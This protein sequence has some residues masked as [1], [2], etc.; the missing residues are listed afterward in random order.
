MVKSNEFFSENYKQSEA[1]QEEITNL[2]TKEEF[3]V[4]PFDIQS[5]FEK[6]NDNCPIK[7]EHMGNKIP[8][9]RWILYNNISRPDLV[10]KYKKPLLIEIKHKNKKYLWINSRDYLDYIKWEDILLI[11]VYIIMFVKDENIFYIHRLE[12]DTT[13]LKSL[14]TQHDGNKVFD[15]QK[16]SIKIQNKNELIKYLKEESS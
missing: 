6:C 14:I 7:I 10:I 9:A 2:F 12:K 3:S 4:I 1:T 16:D 5:E 11:P 13:K 15:V 8:Y